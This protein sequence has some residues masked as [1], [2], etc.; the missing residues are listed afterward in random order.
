MRFGLEL[1]ELSDVFAG[2]GL[3]PF[4]QA[5]SSEQGLIG[6][7]VVPGAG[8]WPRKRLDELPQWVSQFGA[9]AVYWVKPKPGALGSSIKKA[10]DEATLGRLLEKTG[11]GAQDLILIIAGPRKVV[12]ASLAQLRVRAAAE[13]G[14][15]PTGKSSLV[16][17]ENFPLFE[18]NDEESRY[19]AVHHPFTA[20]RDEDLPLLE[21]DPG[22][23]RAKAYDLVWNGVEIAG[24]SIRIHRRDVQEKCF[25]VLRLSLDQAREKFSFLLRAL[26]YG[27]P[28]HGGIA[29][30]F[31]R[32]L[33][34]LAGASSIRDVIAFPK[35]MSGADP[36]TEAP[37]P[38]DKAQLEALKLISTASEQE[39]A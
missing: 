32:L 17:V 10:L 38:V 14:L 15:V 25:G 3:V 12:Q 39:G 28:P 19:D 21:T 31:D 11:A 6:G 4:A 9:G 36:L 37:F 1:V 8:E 35:T 26:E 23:V 30:G 29:F 27:A 13:Q 7:I 34:L 20:P 2:T 18:W 33:M 24:G 5:L 22:K 16:W